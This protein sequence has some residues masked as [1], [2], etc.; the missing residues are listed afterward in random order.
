MA[1]SSSPRP[2]DD[3][4][5][6]SP[7]NSKIDIDEHDEGFAIMASSS[8]PLSEIDES[9]NNLNCSSISPNNLRGKFR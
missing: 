4:S 8:L 3:N 9:P 1:S 7:N 5:A 6:N 2:R